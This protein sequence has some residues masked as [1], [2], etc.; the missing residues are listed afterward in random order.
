MDDPILKKRISP[1]I[2]FMEVHTHSHLASGEKRKKWYH[3]F[4]EFLML[5]LAVF[6]GFLAENFREHQVEKQRAKQYAST[7]LEDLKTDNEALMSG[8]NMNQIII[9]KID[10]LLFLY[11]PENKQ[12]KTTGQLYFYGRHGSYFWHYVNK[13]VTLEQMKNS[14]TIRYFH[15]SIL[16]N[17]FVAL[18]KE[19]NFIQYWEN[20]EAIFREQSLPYA[21]SLFNYTVLKKIPP[22]PGMLEAAVRS[23]SSIEQYRQFSHVF[24]QTNP[25]LSNDKLVKE[26]LNFCNLRLPLVKAKIKVYKNTLSDMEKLTMA[27]KKE[28]HLK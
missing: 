27:L 10:T 2:N 23:D 21:S 13:Q 3:Y 6:C 16:E 11:S 24:L 28:F 7:M 1:E 20:K 19:I 17:K 15:N 4:W 5:F 9:D 26:Y 14:G 8:I 18:D 25:P 22:D 12:T